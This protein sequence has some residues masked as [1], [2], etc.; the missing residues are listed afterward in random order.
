MAEHMNRTLLEKVWCMLSNAGLGKEFWAEAITYACHLINRLPSAA[1]DGKTPFEKWYLK[2]VVDYDSFHVFGSIAYYHV[3]ESKLDPRA[4]KTI[5]MGI[6]SG[7]KGYRLRCPMTKK[8]ICNREV[9]FDES[10]MVNKVTEDTKQN[11][12]VSKQ[13]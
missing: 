7:V 3:T 13:V 12:G 6:T 11:E 1:I 10:A 9:T 2:H 8:V 5:F 4:K